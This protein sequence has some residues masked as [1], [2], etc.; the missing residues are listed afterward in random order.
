MK[1]L[2]YLL[3]RFKQRLTSLFHE[4]RNE[5]KQFGWFGDYS[6]WSAAKKECSGYEAENILNAVKSS[7]VQV[8]NGEAVYERDSVL[9]DEIVYSPHLI[10][11]FQSSLKNG[12][13][14]V[15]DFGG[16][17]GSSYFQHRNLFQGLTDFKWAVVEQTH[18]VE[19][20]KNDIA[21]DELKFYH[22]IEEAL[23]NQ[24]AQVLFLSSVIQYFEE[25][26]KL[27]ESL[28]PYNFEFII[29]DRT[30]FVDDARERITKQ[31]VPEFI[32][33][34]SYPAW[35]LNEQKFVNAFSKHFE[36]VSDFPSSFDSDGIQEDGKRV[37]RKGFYFK[38]KVEDA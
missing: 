37:Y 15:I 14:H 30:A 5:Q 18:F 22:T 2:R 24:N 17:L 25:P 16:S 3:Y 23:E 21:I 4:N 13:L 11:V 36:L 32:Y 19:C 31:I 29:F 20:G 9:F 38:R 10:E 35:F 27:I 34:A 6:S 28:L 8:R 26:Y 33:K 12:K 7:V 1:K